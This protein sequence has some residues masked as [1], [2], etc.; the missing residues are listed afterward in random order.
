MLD[1]QP[2]CTC[3]GQEQTREQDS[4]SPDG[5]FFSCSSIFSG[6]SEAPLFFFSVLL[7]FMTCTEE[8]YYLFLLQAL[9]MHFP[10]KETKGTEEVMCC[11]AAQVKVSEFFLLIRN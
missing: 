11:A 2:V 8:A 10:M 9:N 4:F 7:Q 3:V 6:L 1:S 5:L